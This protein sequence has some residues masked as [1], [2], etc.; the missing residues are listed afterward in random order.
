MGKVSE[1]QLRAQA[2]ILAK[3]GYSYAIIADK[4]K[5]SKRWVAK[6]VCRSRICDKLFDKHRSGRPKV[7]SNTA[8][9][10]VESVKYKRGQGVRQIANRLKSS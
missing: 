5:R 9:R 6:W 2:V 10:I 4:L 3:E 7:L 8:K 1:I